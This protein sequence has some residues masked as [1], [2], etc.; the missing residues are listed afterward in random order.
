ISLKMAKQAEDDKMINKG[1]TYL[2]IADKFG[3]ES[4]HQTLKEFENK[5][6]LNEKIEKQD[7]FK[8]AIRE[9]LKLTSTQLLIKN[10]EGEISLESV[11]RNYGEQ[12]QNDPYT[13]SINRFYTPLKCVDNENEMNAE[14]K[15]VDLYDKLESFMNSNKK[16]FLLL[17]E[18]G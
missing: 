7:K 16:V 2:S 3:D 6:A 14:K 15:S 11:L 18:A 8:D 5:K 9:P 13:Q 17:G 10:T 4:V 12:V 1:I